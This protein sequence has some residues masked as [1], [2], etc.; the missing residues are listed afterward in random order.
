[1]NRVISLI[2]LLALV[3]VFGVLFYLVVFRFFVPLFL[4]AL[5]AMLFEPMHRWFMKR[6]RGHDRVAAGLTATAILL[7]VLIPT[8]TVVYLG[9]TMPCAFC[10]APSAC[11]STN[12]RSTG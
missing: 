6:C 10:T 3:A 8:V 5:F 9:A 4:A 12:N 11:G 2:V 7:I 1:M